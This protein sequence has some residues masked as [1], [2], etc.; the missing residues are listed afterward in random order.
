[1]GDHYK[2]LG[3]TKPSNA[4]EIKKAFRKL[5]LKHHPDKGG[6]P[7]LFKNI[8][9]AYDVLSDSTKK[10]LYDK[11][12]SDFEKINQNGGGSNGH[13]GGMSGTMHHGPFNMENLFGSVF[14]GMQRGPKKGKETHH[15]LEISLNDLYKGKK[16]KMAVTRNGK[17]E[18]CDGKG[19]SQVIENKCVPCIGKG[20]T[21]SSQGSGFGFLQQRIPC[22]RCATTGIMKKIIE[23]CKKC[24]A[25]GKVTVRVIIEPVVKPG[26]KAGTKYTFKGLGDYLG[27]DI[28]TGDIVLTLNQ[29]NHA[30]KRK[31][32]DIHVNQEISI[33]QSLTGFSIEIEHLDGRKIPINVPRGTVTPPGKV[34]RI[35]NE[36][37]PRNKGNLVVTFSVKFP[38]KIS[39]PSLD[40]LDKCF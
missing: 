6:D 22:Q 33:K 37:I 3:L 29:K 16:M 21:V 10:S 38:S 14:G 11:Y 5:A 1:M 12:G 39:E 34:I 30:F 40:M 19:G 36:G 35:K 27:E 23:P 8:S 31:G 4:D 13:F 24:H 2:T 15:P 9:E 7:E 28:Q 20:F 26:D 17:C 32:D 25:T 18:S